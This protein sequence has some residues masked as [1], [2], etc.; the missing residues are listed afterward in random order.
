MLYEQT[1]TLLPIGVGRNHGSPLAMISTLLKVVF[2]N[3]FGNYVSM[4]FVTENC[5]FESDGRLFDVYL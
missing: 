3:T 2:L 4:T 1:F 5:W